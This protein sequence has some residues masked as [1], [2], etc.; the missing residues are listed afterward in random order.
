M[1]KLDG[2]WFELSVGDAAP[3]DRYKYLIDDATEV[4]D[5][6][7]RFQPADVHGPSEI[8]DP[9]PLIGAMKIGRD[10]LGKRRLSM[11]ST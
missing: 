5:P 3:G 1:A 8:V 2:G 7:S 4:P 6:A 9:T 10:V 11:N